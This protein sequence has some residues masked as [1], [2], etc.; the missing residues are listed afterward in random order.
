MCLVCNVQL[1]EVTIVFPSNKRGGPDKSVEEPVDALCVWSTRPIRHAAWQHYSG[2]V[3]A[4]TFS[5]V[6]LHKDSVHQ[7]IIEMCLF[8]HELF[9]I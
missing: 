4:Y 9:K 6:K 7:N 5:Y 3:R 1:T 2:K 8:F